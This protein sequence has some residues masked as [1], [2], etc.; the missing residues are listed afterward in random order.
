[1][2]KIL[3]KP[4]NVIDNSDLPE[5]SLQNMPEG[6]DPLEI[7]G[8]LYFVCELDFSQ[9]NNF[10]RVGLIPLIVRNPAKVQNIKSYINCLAIA[11]RRVEFLKKDK[12]CDLDDCDEMII[13]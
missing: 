11:H 6:G 9:Q 7:E 4:F 12:I 10:T 1:M 5:I 8:E 2:N 3:I 13:S